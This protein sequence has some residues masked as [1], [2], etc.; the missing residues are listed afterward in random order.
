MALTLSL[1][2]FIAFTIESAIGFGGLL[3]SFA[4]LAFFMD[5]KTL[6]PVAIYVGIVASLMILATNRSNIDF[7]LFLRVFPVALIGVASGSFLFEYFDSEFL[8]QI[9]SIFLVITALKSLIFTKFTLPKLLQAP[10]VFCGG[11]MQ[12]I[13]GIGGPF[14]ILALKDSFASK[15]ALRSTM[16]IY[17]VVFN[18]LR[19]LQ[20]QLMG[21]I[22][23]KEVFI[24]WWLIFPLFLAAKLG[25]K[26]HLYVPE[27]QFKK[28]VNILLLFAGIIYILR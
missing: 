6:V 22:G 16:A 19:M 26:L 23:F 14:T 21:S 2:F 27:E 4:V 1:I 15:T 17:F 3:V 7:K 25:Y 18:I 11:L 8:L 20:L 5:I 28:L 12:G 24:N 10:L 9:F 13:Y